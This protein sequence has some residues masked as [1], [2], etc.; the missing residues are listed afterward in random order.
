MPVSYTDID[1]TTGNRVIATTGAAGSSRDAMMGGPAKAGFND[2]IDGTSNSICIFEAAGKVAEA[3]STGADWIP[4][5]AAAA[6]P[7]GGPNSA[8]A[9][10]G[11]WANAGVNGTG[12]TSTWCGASNAAFCPNR[13]ADPASGDGVS[14]PWANLATTVQ[15]GTD[16]R[17]IN[18]NKTPRNGPTACPWTRK[19]CG[20]NTEPFSYHDGGAQA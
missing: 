16:T 6:F 13:W 15:M 12:V 1:P 5:T 10:A 14:G 4:R 9:A 11:F 2:V 18:N 17:V 3:A 20:P 19:E 8:N 7:G